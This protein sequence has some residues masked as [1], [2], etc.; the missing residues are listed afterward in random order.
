M[1]VFRRILAWYQGSFAQQLARICRDY[2]CDPMGI[3]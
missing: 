1:L 3:A 2:R